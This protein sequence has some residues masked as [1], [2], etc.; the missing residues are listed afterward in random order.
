MNAEKTTGTPKK[1]K[2]RLERSKKKQKKKVTQ[3]KNR[4]PIM[5][6]KN[7]LS[8]SKIIFPLCR[9]E[10]LRMQASSLVVIRLLLDFEG[11]ASV[12]VLGSGG[13][14]AGDDRRLAVENI[15]TNVLK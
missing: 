10:V 7:I 12:L 5:Q 13:R 15:E 3:K 2:E 9:K 1:K 4:F 8:D 6:E 14:V 11:L